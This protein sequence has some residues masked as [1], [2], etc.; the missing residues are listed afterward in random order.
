MPNREWFDGGPNRRTRE[1]WDHAALIAADQRNRQT[2]APTFG[3]FYLRA[4]G[5]AAGLGLLVGLAV[6]AARLWHVYVFPLW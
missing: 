5:V 4:F 3:R 6:M 1:H 2:A